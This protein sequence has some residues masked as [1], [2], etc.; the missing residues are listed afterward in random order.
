MKGFD[1]EFKSPT[2]HPLA[3]VTRRRFDSETRVAEP[4]MRWLLGIIPVSKW[5]AEI[6]AFLEPHRFLCRPPLRFPNTTT[7]GAEVRTEESIRFASKRGSSFP[8]GLMN[9]HDVAQWSGTREDIRISRKFSCFGPH[10]IVKT[11]IRELSV[12]TFEAIEIE[13]TKPY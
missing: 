12:K 9:K 11:C 13:T 1:Y 7:S 3:F 8:S 4:Y 2:W 10:G 5:R 6:T